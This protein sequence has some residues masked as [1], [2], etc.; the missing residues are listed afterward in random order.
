MTLICIACAVCAAASACGMA[1]IGYGVVL[2]PEKDSGIEAGEIVPVTS[3][4]KSRD[5]CIFYDQKNKKS[6]LIPVWRIER[7]DSKK[8]A[9]AFQKKF[10]GFENTYAYGERDGVP[11]VR[12]QP[13]NSTGVKIITKPKAGQI[14]KIIGRS[15]EKARIEDMS[16]YWY[17][18][19]IEYQGIGRNGEFVKLG[20]RGFCY[21][22]YLKVFENSSTSEKEIAKKVAD[23]NTDPALQNVLSNTWRPIYFQEMIDRGKI[24]TSLFNSDIGIFP[25]PLSKVIEIVTPRG[26][27]NFPYTEIL[28]VKTDAFSFK[29]SGL[30]IEV[31]SDRKISATFNED[32]KQVTVLYVLIDDDIDEL[33]EKEVEARNEYF[34]SFYKQGHLLESSA[35]G[36]ISLDE[37]KR[38][39]WKNFNR[40][41]PSIIPDSV[42]GTGWIDFPYILSAELRKSYDGVITFYFTELK[43]QRNFSFAYTFAES[44]VRMYY[45]PESGIDESRV[46]KLGANPIVIFF[47][48]VQS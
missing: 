13:L 45:V 1:K 37:K 21:G 2:W 39:T 25:L 47:S 34:D 23:S 28:K 32:G 24:N 15:E 18:V 40:L 9:K 30:R 5:T 8:D 44:G 22:Y 10:E 16:D 38:I 19:L 20:A 17:E 11:P 7:F 26:K 12:E 33:Y 6:V 27:F 3:E 4:Q 31:L 35:Y 42:S 43:S 36:S 29:D 48:F 41:V 46:T 14:F